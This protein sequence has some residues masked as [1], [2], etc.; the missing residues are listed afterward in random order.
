MSNRGIICCLTVCF[1]I[2]AVSLAGDAV[3][4]HRK[5]LLVAD[6]M[7]RVEQQLLDHEGYSSTVYQCSSGCLTIGIG[8]NIQSR[9]I[10]EMEALYLL[11]N[12][13]HECT[14]DLITIF[15]KWND[16]SEGRKVALVDMRFNLGRSKFL[17]FEQMIKAIRAGNFTLAAQEMQ[18]SRWYLQVGRRGERLVEMILE[19]E[20]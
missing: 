19:V 12:D 5:L 13:I 4:V 1:L 3:S 17:E 9:G 15:P 11:R 20:R 14:L 6:N 8:R 7:T 2:Y 18:R 10:S 16:L